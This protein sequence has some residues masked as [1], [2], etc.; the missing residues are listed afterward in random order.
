MP[1]ALTFL[2][3]P[4]QFSRLLHFTARAWRLAVDRRL[5]AQGLNQA[6]WV[7]VSTIAGA[8]AP[9]TQSELAAAL[10]LEGATVVS[11]IDK[12]VRQGLVERVMT[13][14][15]RRKRLLVVTDAGQAMYR[16]VKGEADALREN[17]LASLAG[18]DLAVTMRVLE[19]LRQAAEQSR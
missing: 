5:K 11:M 9:L 2:P 13:P 14:E 12:L 4:T 16:Q 18:E 3:D 6:S 15:D 7:T 1:D 8:D 17:L 10:G 19:T